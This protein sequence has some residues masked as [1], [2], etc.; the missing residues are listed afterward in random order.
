MSASVDR[1]YDDVA[2]RSAG[3]HGRADSV[4]MMTSAAWGRPVQHA[5]LTE[6]IEELPTLSTTTKPTLRSISTW[7]EQVDWLIPSCR[8][9]SPTRSA[10]AGEVDSTCSSRTRVGSASSAEPLGVVLDLGV[11]ERAGLGRGCGGV[12]RGERHGDQRT[13]CS[14]TRDRYS[15]SSTVIDQPLGGA[16]T[17]PVVIIGA[18]PI[19]LAA[20]AHAA[21]R[22]LDVRRPGVRAR[23]RAPPSASGPTSGC[24]PRGASW[25]TRRRGGCSR[26]PATWT[27]AR[28]PTPTPRA[29]SGAS[30]TCSRSPTCSPPGPVAACATT[31]R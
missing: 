18:G 12:D 31:P 27:R 19:G 3:Q 20:A 30:A 24:S 2:G 14:S 5:A 17:H 28:T 13:L 26:R 8:A 22:G 7:W 23:T 29:A 25:S 9:S 1:A 16:V 4:P 21:E 15:L 10:P 11:G 6:T